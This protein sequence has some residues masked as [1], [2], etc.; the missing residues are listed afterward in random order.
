MSQNAR[1]QGIAAF[2]DVAKPVYQNPYAFSADPN[3]DYEQFRLGYFVARHEGHQSVIQ[4]MRGA[5]LPAGYIKGSQ[6]YTA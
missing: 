5:E 4:N 6:R 2:N 3:S 1:T